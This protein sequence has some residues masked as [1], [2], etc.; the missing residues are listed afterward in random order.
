MLVDDLPATVGLALEYLG[1]ARLETR[2]RSA[3]TS[4]RKAAMP[5]ADDRVVI[6]RSGRARIWVTRSD[7]FIATK[8]AAHLVIDRAVAGRLDVGRVEH[9]R[10]AAHNAPSS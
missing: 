2:W 1:V 9:H 6:E 7:G 3:P 4:A 5:E 8:S 10:A